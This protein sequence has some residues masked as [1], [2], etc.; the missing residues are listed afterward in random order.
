MDLIALDELVDSTSEGS[1]STT[2][3]HRLAEIEIALQKYQDFWNEFLRFYLRNNLTFPCLEETAKLINCMPG[4]VFKVPDTKYKIMKKFCANKI[5][6]HF[7]IYCTNCKKYIKGKETHTAICSSCEASVSISE[8]QYFISIN[9]SL[10]LRKIL[11]ANWNRITKYHEK[12][13]NAYENVCD[14]NN[15]N[16]VRNLVQINPH[17]LKLSL[18]VNTDGVQVSKSGKQSLWPIQLICNFLPPEIRF[19]RKN[20][21]V[22]ALYLGAQKPNMLAFFQPLCEEFQ[23]INDKGIEVKIGD[24]SF[25]LNVHVTHCS[26]DLPAQS[27]AQGIKL[28]CGHSACSSCLHYD[29]PTPNISNSRSYV[30][31]TWAGVLDEPRTHAKTLL[32]MEKIADQKGE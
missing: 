24:E 16:I 30:R 6:M 21:I 28:Y 14:I 19:D 2:H 22:A 23:Q 15:G 4:N 12:I 18:L 9:S 7:H 11:E 25:K 8:N 29:V 31:Y 3:N 1:D 20:I 13:I 10:Q 27:T 26:A 17:N 5:P 32:E